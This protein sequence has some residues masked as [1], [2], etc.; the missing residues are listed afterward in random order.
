MLVQW[1]RESRPMLD[2]SP[3]NQLGEGVFTPEQ[4]QELIAGGAVYAAKTTTRRG[5][6]IIV[7]SRRPVQE[8]IHNLLSHTAPVKAG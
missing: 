8:V 1:N 6:K 7:S 4:E 2:P 3:E 5:H